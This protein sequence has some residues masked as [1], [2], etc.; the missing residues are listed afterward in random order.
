MA[1]N[2]NEEGISEAQSTASYFLEDTDFNTRGNAIIV[3]IGGGTT[4]M[5]HWFNR[6][7]KWEDSVK[8]AGSDLVPFLNDLLN[9]INISNQGY[10]TYEIEMRKWPFVHRN[11]DGKMEHFLNSPES[12]NTLLKINL[13]F[14][15]ICYYIGMHLKR[16]KLN[17]PLNQ[18]VFAGNGIRFLEIVTVGNEL[19]E[20]NIE[21]SKWIKLFREMLKSGHGLENCEYNTSFIFSK[22]PKLEVA[23]GLVS[24]YLKNYSY[25]GSKTKKMF[26]LD[27]HWMDKRY[28]SDEW[29]SEVKATDFKSFNID[30]GKFTNFINLYKK[31]ANEY[32]KDWPIESLPE[33]FT[34]EM[35]DGFYSSLERRGEEEL[36]SSLFFEALK[37]YLRYPLKR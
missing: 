31:S 15:G 14:A 36:A 33:E 32:F 25:E 18:L 21:L 11:W 16:E 37:E 4:D 6:E 22:K 3:D 30:F 27:I 24:N 26:G 10:S 9:L 35:K 5:S 7:L 20:Q 17:E 29:S 2:V 8:F 13:F 1:L 12:K 19:S 28:Q 34:K 23:F